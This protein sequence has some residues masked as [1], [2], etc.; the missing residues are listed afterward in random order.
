LNFA[1]FY[2][3]LIPENWRLSRRQSSRITLYASQ[4]LSTGHFQRFLQSTGGK[5]SSIDFVI[6]VLNF[7][8]Q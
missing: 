5:L 2:Y 6:K 3:H 4:N 1:L 7:Q 8:G